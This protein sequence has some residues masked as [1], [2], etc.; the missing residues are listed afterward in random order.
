[1]GQLTTILRAAAAAV[2]LLPV[3]AVSA[4]GAAAGSGAAEH[5]RPI[6][7]ERFDAPAPDD[8]NATMVRSA[9]RNATRY[10]LTTWWQERYGGQTGRYLE[11]GGV[12]EQHVRQPAA[13]AYAIAVALR[14]GGY[15]PE[16]TG[17]SAEQARAVAVRLAASIAY[18]H[19][20]TSAG[21]W[22]DVW[23]SAL[24][25]YYAGNAAWLLWDHLAEGDREHVASMLEFEADR[26]LEYDVPYFRDRDG[27]VVFPGDSKAEENAW[28]ANLLQLV[29]AMMPRHRHHAQW[30]T[31]NVELM[32]SAFA[33]PS[34]LSDNRELHGRPVAD[35][36]GGSNIAE[37]GTL[38][39]HGFVHPDY[40]ATVAMN[41]SGPMTY[42]LAGMRTPEASRFNA[43]VVYAA[44][45]AVSF[46]SPPYRAPGGTIYVPDAAGEPGPG[47]Y[48]PQGNDWGTHRRAHL[49]VADAAAHLFGFD[50]DTAAAAWERQHVG[51]LLEMQ[52]R[53]T[54]GRTY[55]APGED[56]YAGRESWVSVEIARA[57][58]AHWLAAQDAVRWTDQAYPVLEVAAEGPDLLPAGDTATVTAT[59]RPELTDASAARVELSVSAGDG[60]TATP[61]G[62]SA[63]A[64]VGAAGVTTTVRLAAAP[65]AAGTTTVTLRARYRLLGAWH[66]TVT[67]LAVP[68]VPPPPTADTWLSD[69]PWVS[70]TVGYGQAPLRDTNYYGDPIA[71][72]GTAHEKGLWTHAPAALTYHLGGRCAELTAVVGI[73]DAMHELGPD[74]GSVGYRVLVDGELVHDTG[75]ITGSTPPVPI[76][77]DVT[78]ARL[79]RLEV[80]DAGD[81]K[82]YDHAVWGSARVTCGP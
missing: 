23:Q 61:T 51:T 9:L 17:V 56:T 82:S 1:M 44:L 19:R 28:N 31:K 81:G 12:A 39:N 30:M 36:L 10:A 45:T 71:V 55:Q 78:G 62:P 13:Q 11:L 73:D 27:T 50:G 5:V 68:V 47:V 72:G 54:D 24:W 26:F 74:R 63:W 75:R 59:L 6:D 32:L 16:A 57:Q 41:A 14:T 48:Y 40:M 38:V 34:D 25:A 70:A 20:A 58:L 64:V 76:A 66:E 21:G 80:T 65:D 49:V 60:V 37:D 3:A 29:T 2:L 15:D 18:R 77:V 33:R 43:D 67:T 35:W 69:L 46:P 7:W 79:L 22:G 4:P 42:G 53:G 8:E 52:A